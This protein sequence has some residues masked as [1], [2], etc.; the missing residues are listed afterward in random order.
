M[1]L[2]DDIQKH[3][4]SYRNLNVR[5]EL[6]EKA[7]LPEGFSALITSLENPKPIFKRAIELGAEKILGLP[8]A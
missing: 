7:F 2:D 1:I 4:T 6:P 3:G 5:I 8:I